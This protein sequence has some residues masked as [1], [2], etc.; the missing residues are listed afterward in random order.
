VNPKAFIPAWLNK[1]SLSQADFRVYCCLAARA[2]TKTGIAWP[3]AETIASDCTM[4]RRTVWKSLRS[5]E[6]K[7]LIRKSGKPFAGSN[8]Y[9]VLVPIGAN[10][11]PIEDA[12]ISANEAPV[13]VSPIGAPFASSIGANEAPGKTTNKSNQIRV[14]KREVSPEGIEFADWFKSTLP[15]TV[16]LG[17]NWRESFA[18]AHDDLVR[19]DKRTPEQI[20]EV[21]RWART[22]SFWKTN[23]MSPSKLRDRKDGI[24]WFDIFAEKMKPLT[25]NGSTSTAPQPAGTATVNG[26]IFTY[27][28]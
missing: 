12:P 11:A 19:L 14:T 27:K 1:A 6:E 26:R 15:E 25:A 9:M 10:E 28:P 16:N 18:K 13:D 2:D 20:S 24:Q 21:S 17:S 5:L 23:F 22:D 4:A 8:R 3:Q 7:K